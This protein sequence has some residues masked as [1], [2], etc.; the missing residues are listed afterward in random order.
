MCPEGRART[1]LRAMPRSS[2]GTGFRLH[3]VPFQCSSKG[4][5]T[6][7]PQL[8]QPDAQISVGE[9]ALI[10]P[11]KPKLGMVGLFTTR[12]AVPFQ[13]SMTGPLVRAPT[14][15]TLLVERAVTPNRPAM[16]G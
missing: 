2:I 10:L 3:V 14:A 15:H 11:R 9:M 12:Q 13:R 5:P 6:A 16:I 7:S 1:V 8:S 4:A